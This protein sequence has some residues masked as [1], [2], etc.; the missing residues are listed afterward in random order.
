MTNDNVWQNGSLSVRSY[1]L[2]QDTHAHDFNQIVIPLAGA[3]EV[4]IDPRVYTV[5]VGHCIVIPTG[6][7]HRYSAPQKSK[8]LVADMGN[9]P[10]NI[11]NLE[12]PCVAISADLMAFCNYSDVHLTHAADEETTR[13]LYALFWCLLG[14]QDFRGRVDERVM[15]AVSLMDEDLSVSHSTE[16]LAAAACLSVSQ[17]K[18]LFKKSFNIPASTYLTERRMERAKTLLANTDYPISVVA[19]EVGYDDAS[20]FTRRFTAHFGQSPRHYSRTGPT[21]NKNG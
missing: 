15:R 11:G 8:F 21:A 19:A 3:M 1:S 6:T 2:K 17:F 18:A 16:M 20:A 12:V 13:L 5:A 7:I 9:L 10:E 4:A 14:Q